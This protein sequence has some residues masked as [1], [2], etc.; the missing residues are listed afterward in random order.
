M[1]AMV[2]TWDKMSLKGAEFCRENITLKYATKKS[3]RR[4]R[5]EE[6]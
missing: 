4:R 2:Q 6:N 5:R 1:N 3:E